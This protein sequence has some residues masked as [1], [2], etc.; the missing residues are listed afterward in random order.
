[1]AQP[2][3]RPT[4]RATRLDS[5]V[6]SLYQ[7][8]FG[9]DEAARG[10]RPPAQLQALLDVEAALADALVDAGVAPARCAAV[11][12]RVARVEDFDVASIAAQAADAG[13]VAIPLVRQLTERV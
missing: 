3:R 8:L 2:Q 5:S 6:N 10:V 12:R 4:S 9:D 1:M 7:S 13:N 11:I